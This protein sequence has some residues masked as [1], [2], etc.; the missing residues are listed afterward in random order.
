MNLFCSRVS[1]HVRIVAAIAALVVAHAANAQNSVL[2]ATD[3]SVGFSQGRGGEF[4]LRSNPVA[5]IGVSARKPL[6]Y[7]I[8]LDAEVDYD[9]SG[10]LPDPDLT[11]IVDS[12][13]GCAPRFPEIGGPVGLVGVTLGAADV[14]QLRVNAGLAAYSADNTRLGTP[15]TAIDIAGA[16]MSSL[17]IV[18][19]W[20]AFALPDYRGD[21]LT[22]TS[23]HL[24]LRLQ[25]RR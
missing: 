14:V 12:R 20:R 19:G 16:P 10:R 17:A 3:A 21:R 2:W 4:A 24:G 13:G 9:W 11:C 7:N 23:W 1:V 8:G 22:V 15:V 5:E 25:A 6:R 18:A